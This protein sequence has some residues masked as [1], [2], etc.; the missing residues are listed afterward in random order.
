MGCV[1]V[2]KNE[3][4][5]GEAYA[6]DPVT[7]IKGDGP[8]I[9]GQ[10]HSGLF[11][12]A[13]IEARLNECGR[14]RLDTDWHVDR[15]Y[16]G[17]VPGASI[18]RANFHRY[19]IDANR[20]PSGASL[21]PGQ[22]TTGLVPVVTFDNAPIWTRAPDDAEIEARRMLYHAAYH[23]A[24]AGE[25]ARVKAQHGFSVLYDCH[26]IRSEAPFLFEGRLPDLNLGDNGGKTCDRAITRA[27]KKA[28]K[29]QNVFSY[30]VNGRFRGGWTTRQ[31]GRPHENIHAI[32]MEIAQSCYLE[33]QAPPF[34][35]DEER[36][37]ALRGV[38]RE[39]LSEIARAASGLYR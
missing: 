37:K 5:I 29:G 18:V 24:L 36:A 23:R 19:V 11:I 13:E 1:G 38:L 8:V 30:V 9:L 21:Y 39:I 34:A 33:T 26:S 3:G 7:V 6:M 16:D 25:I 20:D 15:L 35:Y 27:A 2:G 12:P 32:Q 17:L 10:P 4:E 31:Y 28:C 14:A 22:N